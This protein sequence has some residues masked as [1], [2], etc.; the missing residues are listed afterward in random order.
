VLDKVDLYFSALSLKGNVDL[1]AFVG[2]AAPAGNTVFITRSLDRGAHW[3]VP[4]RIGARRA[5]PAYEPHLLAINPNSVALLWIDGSEPLIGQTLHLYVSEDNGLSW[6]ARKPYRLPKAARGLSAAVD[7][8]GAIH[9][10][11]QLAADALSTYSTPFH[12]VWRDRWYGAALTSD[13]SRAFGTAN[14]DAVGA[15]SLVISWSE[16][17]S[18]AAGPV[19]ATRLVIQ[20]AGCF[21]DDAEFAPQ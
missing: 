1:V 4:V 7:K 6:S 2:N 11:V 10:L 16:M 14:I 15:D 9:V 3:S 21:S 13:A 19:P 17:V 20:R 12:A 5:T 8:F 18:S